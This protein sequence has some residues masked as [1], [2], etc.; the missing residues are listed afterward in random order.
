MNDVWNDSEAMKEAVDRLTSEDIFKLLV[1]KGEEIEKNTDGSVTM[2][3]FDMLRSIISNEE[4]PEVPY[5]KDEL[6]ARYDS[7]DIIVISDADQAL[8]NK[9][10][11]DLGLSEEDADT[12]GQSGS[13]EIYGLACVKVDGLRNLFVYVVP[14]MGDII[15][16]NDTSSD[17][18]NLEPVTVS[19]DIDQKTKLKLRRKSTLYGISRLTDGLT[20]SSG[21]EMLHTRPSITQPLPQA[22]RLGQQIMTSHV[23][24]MPRQ[25]HST[26]RTPT[27][28]PTARLSTAHITHAPSSSAQEATSYPSRFSPRTHS[29]AARTTTLLKALLRLCRR[30][31]PT[32]K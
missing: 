23:Y 10:R 19:D 25:R 32:L 26:S 31:S 27:S 20:S 5:D 4:Y 30:T 22:I 11:S 18:V 13:L 9:V 1:L 28:T 7:G 12:F 24:A 15:T 17:D 3:R 29:T 6:Q 2:Q 21:W 8:V 16:S 14:R